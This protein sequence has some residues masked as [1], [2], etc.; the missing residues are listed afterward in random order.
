VVKIDDDYNTITLA[1]LLR[2]IDEAVGVTPKDDDVLQ[3]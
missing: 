1:P 2:H 3:I